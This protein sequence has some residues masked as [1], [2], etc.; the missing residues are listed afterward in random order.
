MILNAILK[1]FLKEQIYILIKTMRIRLGECNLIKTIIIKQKQK[2]KIQ[3]NSKTKATDETL[4]FESFVHTRS[5]TY[6]C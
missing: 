3:I 1:F 5:A 2:V 4:L 6:K